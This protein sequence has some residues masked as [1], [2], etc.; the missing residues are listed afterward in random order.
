MRS[1]SARGA[2]R[3]T[4]P[5]W[6]R[7]PAAA[8][9]AILAVA[10]NAPVHRVDEAH[11]AKRLGFIRVSETTRDQILRR[12]GTPHSTYEQGRIV[13]YAFRDRD[14]ELELAYRVP[15]FYLIVVYAADGT[16]VRRGLVQVR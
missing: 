13:A 6:S 5:R 7:H 1:R 2:A 3:S 14:G 10:C 11:A 4:T 8:L 12:L 16:V 15:E 9:A